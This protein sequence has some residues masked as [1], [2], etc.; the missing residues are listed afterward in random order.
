MLHLLKIEE[1]KHIDK[2]GNILWQ[3]NNLNNIF[4]ANGQLY[5]LNVA[6]NTASGVLVPTSY[7]LGLDNRVTLA[8]SDTLAN[9]SQ[10]PTQFA[11]ARQALS[12]L[13]GFEVSQDTGNYKVTSNVVVFQATGGTWGPVRNI[14]LTNVAS[15]TG[16][17]ISS[18]PLTTPRTVSDGTIITMKISLSLVNC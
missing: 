2:E 11:Y 17:L 16:Y 4:H 13:N 3:E 1:I 14:F 10:E 8:L 5:L 7:Y 18:V 12:S 6:F 9:L 15:G